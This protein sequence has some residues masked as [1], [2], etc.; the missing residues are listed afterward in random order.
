M[1]CRRKFE[2]TVLLYS[3]FLSTLSCHQDWSIPIPGV[4]ACSCFLCRECAWTY[5]I[6]VCIS[7]R[8]FE[9]YFI[10]LYLHSSY[11]GDHFGVVNVD[12]I[13][14]FICGLSSLFIW[15]FANSFAT[16]MIFIVIYGFMSGAVFSLCNEL[17]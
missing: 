8:N 12:I 17:D 4:S 16:L 1:E 13:F 11:L 2:Y 9:E 3:C 15:T 7:L 5:H 14:L 10:N 6:G